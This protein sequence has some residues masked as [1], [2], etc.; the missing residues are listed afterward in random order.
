MR[1]ERPGDER[2][3]A[4]RHGQVVGRDDLVDVETRRHEHEL[5][6]QPARDETV[7]RGD[8][9]GEARSG[10]HALVRR[11]GRAIDRDLHA[12]HG[13]RGEAVGGGVVDAAAVGL[14]L[15]RDAGRGEPL[16]DVPACGDA[17][18]LAAAEGDIGNA[19]VGDASREVERLVARSARRATPCRDRIPRSRRGSARCSG[20]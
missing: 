15:E 6:R 17:E 3:A 2:A 20:W 16:E 14:E 10:T 7:D 12:L 1:I 8:R 19:G 5:R 9:G 4:E 11:G 13:E 18:R